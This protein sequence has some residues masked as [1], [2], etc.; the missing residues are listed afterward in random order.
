MPIKPTVVERMLMRLNVVPAPLVDAGL[1][2]FASR[3]IIAAS[4][5]G[6]FET[7]ETPQTVQAL[8]KNIRSSEKGTGVL[9]N[10]LEVLGYVKKNGDQYVNSNI[11]SKWMVKTSPHSLASFMDILHGSWQRFSDFEKTV[12]RGKPSVN[13]WEWMSRHPGTYRQAQLVWKAMA[14]MAGD[15]IVSKVTLPSDAK[16]LFD[17]GGGHGLYAIQFCQKNPQLSAVIFDWPKGVKIAKETIAEES[18]KGRV[19][20]Q[21]GDFNKDKLG[22]DYDVVLL[23][24][25]IHGHADNIVLLRKVF[26]SLNPGG[27]VV[28][29]DFIIDRH[30]S[31]IA[32]TIAPL[33]GLTLLCEV[34]GKTYTFKEVS[35]LLQQVGF[36][37]H[38]CI[39]LKKMPGFG[40]ITAVR[41]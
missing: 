24:N 38:R 2:M 26:Q 29:G 27:M 34:G 36:V 14:R 18:M 21:V 30:Q 25:I 17:V 40:V 35:R 41:R 1:F 4:R 13:A 10:V 32:G 28:I 15:E 31:G 7:L 8:A 39:M 37:D 23:F 3:A 6:V 12:R 19:M 22:T 11:A 33:L 20:T 5:L 16:R 9:L